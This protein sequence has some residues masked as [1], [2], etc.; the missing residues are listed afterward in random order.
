MPSKSERSRNTAHEAGRLV[1]KGEMQPTIDT[2]QGQITTLTSERN[3]ATAQVE[4]ARQNV[5]TLSADLERANEESEQL[6]HR[7]EEETA[8]A[9]LAAERITAL[10]DELRR[11]QEE[12]ER[13]KIDLTYQISQL[14]EQL[15]EVIAEQ[16]RIEANLAATALSRDEAEVRAS[17]L[18]AELSRALLSIEQLQSSLA[19]E[20]ESNNALR[21][22]LRRLN[23][24]RVAE[25]E[26]AKEDA[27][28]LSAEIQSVK[29]QLQAARSGGGVSPQY[30]ALL[31]EKYR[32]LE[33]LR[34][35]AFVKRAIR[36]YIRNMKKTDT[37]GG[38]IELQVIADTFG[39]ELLANLRPETDSIFS[40][41]VTAMQKEESADDHSNDLL[42]VAAYS[43]RLQVC[44]HLSSNDTVLRE[45]FMNMLEAIYKPYETLVFTSQQSPYTE[46][47]KELAPARPKV[48]TS[49]RKKSVQVVE[50]KPA[51]TEEGTVA[52]EKHD[53]YHCIEQGLP[54]NCRQARLIN[55]I[56]KLVS[57][58]YTEVADERVRAQSEAQSISSIDSL[59][60][61]EDYALLWDANFD[62]DFSGHE[63]ALNTF[64]H[65]SQSVVEV[66]NTGIPADN[67]EYRVARRYVD[68]LERA[69][70]FAGGPIEIQ[71][72]ANMYNWNIS[73]R[74]F[75]G[76]I[77]SGKPQYEKTFKPL[78]YK[79]NPK[80]VSLILFKAGTKAAMF[81]L[82]SEPD[83]EQSIDNLYHVCRV[84]EKDGAIVKE[85]IIAY[86]RNQISPRSRL[87]LF[88]RGEDGISQYFYDYI[89]RGYKGHGD[90]LFEFDLLANADEAIMQ[91]ALKLRAARKTFFKNANLV[92]E[93]IGNE[94]ETELAEWAVPRISLDLSRSTTAIFRGRSGIL[95]SCP[96][97]L[98][99]FALA[100][101][102][103]SA[104]LG[105]NF[106]SAGPDA[107]RTLQGLS[108]AGN[109]IGSIIYS[110][111]YWTEEKR[112]A[113]ALRQAQ[114][115]FIASLPL[116][117]ISQVKI[118]YASGEEEKFGTPS[119]HAILKTK[120]SAAKCIKFGFIMTG[121]RGELFIT[122]QRNAPG[123]YAINPNAQT[124]LQIAAD[125]FV[126][127]VSQMTHQPMLLLLAVLATANLGLTIATEIDVDHQ[128][129]MATNS[130]LG[131]TTGSS[132]LEF[133]S[134]PATANASIGIT[135]ASAL[136]MLINST[137]CG[138]R[139]FCENEVSEA[140]S[141]ISKTYTDNNGV[142]PRGIALLLQRFGVDSQSASALTATPQMEN[143]QRSLFKAKQ[144]LDKHIVHL[145]SEIE[146]LDYPEDSPTR[147]LLAALLEIQRLVDVS[148]I[149]EL[150][151]KESNVLEVLAVATNKAEDQS[152][153][154]STHTAISS[155]VRRLSGILRFSA[156]ASRKK[157]QWKIHLQP[158][159]DC[160]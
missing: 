49:Y 66:E 75:V 87:A 9:S 12:S 127:D 131:N 67:P 128:Q 41:C 20:Q 54:T 92:L 99:M 130:T 60:D 124:D 71:A 113:K 77:A 94:I 29:Q 96:D 90:E 150:H 115:E 46:D 86:L 152:K 158:A 109:A 18:S 134:T 21:E 95:P 108:F 122:K 125:H 145:K 51:Q 84:P 119:N 14:Q 62:M 151:R 57:Q 59:E 31:E 7:L 69:N 74:A 83:I 111:A 85:E 116:D 80:S 117:K 144:E 28:A 78:R 33:K 1:G 50:E 154:V 47:E 97:A 35:E 58:H 68:Y 36:A 64:M 105:E 153:A 155:T 114:D 61:Q 157:N 112:R 37:K 143:I 121:H 123:S 126:Q 11:Q 103:T 24:S 129:T 139:R 102:V 133:V 159:H 22:E 34:K 40:S 52:G 107:Y 5:T 16:K 135:G 118:V 10:S 146:K 98:E 65:G 13:N 32:T 6:Q 72:L 56:C 63:T 136:F 120:W 44:G 79:S 23:N 8:R 110:L 43:L 89:S 39:A 148:N 82:E 25:E 73:V 3:E 104:V 55:N 81:R 106:A 2:L 76:G 156:S 141:F 30:I 100:V 142:I 138:S 48:E 26:R 101:T 70:D 15:E 38:D 88:S 132:T 45:L 42:E 160:D 53:A 19:L 27:E 91:D 17:E 137:C 93:I 147:K 140:L 4:A 149:T